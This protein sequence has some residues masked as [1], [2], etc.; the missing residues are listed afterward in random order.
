MIGLIA[1]THWPPGSV[2]TSPSRR[3]QRASDVM[4]QIARYFSGVDFI[5]HAGDVG[6]EEILAF[7]KKIAPVYL[8]R[9]N[10]DPRVVMGE[11]LKEYLV[12][13]YRGKKILVTH[14]RGSPRNM[15]ERI[16][17][18]LATLHKPD[19]V[20]FGHTHR[21]FL[22][23]IDGVLYINPGSAGDTIFTGENWVAVLDI[24]DDKPEVKFHR[25]VIP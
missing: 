1:D 5:I 17:K 25:I 21:R 15:I 12:I 2:F 23:E 13:P 20:V 6:D 19:I 4:D 7:L 24:V 14:G 3:R 9:G 18:P 11:Q 22:D 16:I 8:V 10:R